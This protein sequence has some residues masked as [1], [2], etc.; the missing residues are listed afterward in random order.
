MNE[1][2]QWPP[3]SEAIVPKDLEVAALRRRLLGHYELDLTYMALVNQD[4]RPLWETVAKNLSDRSG[5]R[6]SVWIVLAESDQIDADVPH[7]LAVVGP[8]VESIRSAGPRLLGLTDRLS[9]QT[10]SWTATKLHADAT[11]REL[12]RLKEAGHII[13]AASPSYDLPIA[14]S[15]NIRIWPTVVHAEL[16]GMWKDE[17]EGYDDELTSDVVP[18]LGYAFD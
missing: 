4:L 12:D 9:K 18:P 7:D 15:C 3:R 10:P 16:P 2:R 13:A 8:Y 1:E 11:R 5:V 6:T 17:F 14:A